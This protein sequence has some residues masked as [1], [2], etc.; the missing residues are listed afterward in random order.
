MCVAL[1]AGSEAHGLI[2]IVRPCRVKRKGKT[3]LKCGDPRGPVVY[4]WSI[5]YSLY[6]DILII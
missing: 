1:D 5:L 6:L 4:F 3:K 2:F